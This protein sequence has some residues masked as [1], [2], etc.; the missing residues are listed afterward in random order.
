MAMEIIATLDIVVVLVVI[1]R[2][3]DV[4]TAPGLIGKRGRW[5][6]GTE[7]RRAYREPQTDMCSAS[8]ATVHAQR[9]FH[10]R[11]MATDEFNGSSITPSRTVN[12]PR[13][14]EPR[15]HTGECSRVFAGI[16]TE[17]DGS[18]L[19]IGRVFRA[20]RAVA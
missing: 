7:L 11:K 2:A 18:A 6:D 15:I 3:I 5:P 20:L 16:L 1:K 10:L 4:T 13:R 12:W 17:P 14:Q 9:A 19:I 8:E